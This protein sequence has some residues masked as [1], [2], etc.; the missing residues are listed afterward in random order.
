MQPMIPRV[1]PCVL[2]C[3]VALAAF[4]LVCREARGLVPLVVDQV[5]PKLAFFEQHKDEF[6]TVF[7][8]TSHIYRG[9]SPEVFDETLRQAGKESHSFNAAADAMASPESI[10]M[11]RRLVALSPRKLKTVFLELTTRTSV[12]EDPER[13]TPRNVYWQ[14]GDALRFAVEK[15]L[16]DLGPNCKSPGAA[17][18]S[19]AMYLRLFARNECNI[20]RGFEALQNLA[21]GVKP[22]DLS[23]ELGP[24]H[25][26]FF[27]KSDPMSAEM[28]T[29]Y[30]EKL[31]RMKRDA[32]PGPTDP[33]N[34]KL[35][36]R[37][38]RDLAAKR[39]SLLFLAPPTPTG[40]GIH[41]Q[42]P[43][44][45]V[46]FAFNDPA[47]FESLYRDDNRLD[48]EHLNEKGAKEFFRMLAQE[49]ARHLES[50]DH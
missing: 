1:I 27:P 8:G 13:I 17:W 2:N 36:A 16:Y 34:E 22:K 48:Y 46:V 24:D 37:L 25:D 20:G 28:L 29:M 11:V 14:D 43:D 47:L 50:S 3:I 33:V 19:L 9:V 18:N 44:G 10:M 4:V 38:F 5:A 15:F 35:F 40:Y 45:A 42:L 41:I 31:E 6:D 12:S 39:I 26:G 23:Y 7:V 21:N 30:H 49:F 32:A